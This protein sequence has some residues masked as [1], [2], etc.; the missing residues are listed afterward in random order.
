MDWDGMG[1][2]WEGS[3]MVLG[4]T[5]RDW[6]ILGGTGRALGWVWEGTGLY[7]FILG[8]TGRDWEVLR[9]RRRSMV[10]TLVSF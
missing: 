9:C 4:Y 2:Y 1:G 10:Y 5:G 8:H 3:E 7:W 6:A